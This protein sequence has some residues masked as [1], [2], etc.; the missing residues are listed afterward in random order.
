M[1]AA[2]LGDG[3]RGQACPARFGRGPKAAELQI[4]RGHERETE[5]AGRDHQP[6]RQARALPDRQLL[7]GV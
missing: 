6:V 1:A 3:G 2:G 7:E 5:P 4:A